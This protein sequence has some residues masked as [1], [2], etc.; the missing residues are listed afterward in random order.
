MRYIVKP[1][2]HLPNVLLMEIG[3]SV[4]AM[5]PHDSI[6]HLQQTIGNQ[7][8]QRLMRSKVRNNGTK[9]NIQT[10]D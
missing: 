10:K 6:I 4:L 9:T 8:V 2:H 5:T 7:A 3:S 1:H